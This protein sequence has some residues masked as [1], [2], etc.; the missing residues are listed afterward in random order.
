MIDQNKILLLSQIVD[1]LNELSEKFEFAYE[2]QDK[3]QFDKS[4][5]AI[6]DF[7]NKLNAILNEK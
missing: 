7:Q 1:S 3:K 2:K 4:K 6:L 5:Q